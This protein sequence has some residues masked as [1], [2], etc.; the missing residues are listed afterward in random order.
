MFIDIG[1]LECDSFAWICFCI[2]S[3]AVR[4]RFLCCQVW[5]PGSQ[6]INLLIFIQQ[7]QCWPE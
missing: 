7:R 2:I 5:C 4:E 3:A 6:N 1:N